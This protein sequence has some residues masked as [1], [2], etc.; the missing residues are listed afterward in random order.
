MCVLLFLSPLQASV[1]EWLMQL[2]L[3]QYEEVMMESGYDDIDFVSSV[4][5]EELT[6]I[7]ITK[8]GQHLYSWSY[9]TYNF[10][11]LMS[12]SLVVHFQCFVILF[13]VH[14]IGI[15]IRVSYY[16]SLIGF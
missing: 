3:N 9:T 12:C 15:A 1:G 4:T 11:F 7:G 13:L 2:G 5:E 16:D 10:S 8:K 14:I 6:D